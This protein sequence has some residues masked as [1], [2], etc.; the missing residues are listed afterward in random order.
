M[1]I[2]HQGPQISKTTQF[3]IPKYTHLFNVYI[4]IHLSDVHHLKLSFFVLF[5]KAV[6]IL[7]KVYFPE[8]LFNLLNQVG[9]EFA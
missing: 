3:S 1:Y 7:K 9:L 8:L 6:N 4:W 2:L 5:E